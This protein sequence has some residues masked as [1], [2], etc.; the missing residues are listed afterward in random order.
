MSTKR[1]TKHYNG[2]LTGHCLYRVIP[3]PYFLTLQ[4]DGHGTISANALT[5]TPSAGY[6]FS[7]YESTGATIVGNDLTFGVED[8]TAKAATYT[9]T[10]QTDGHG[11]GYFSAT[12]YAP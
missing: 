2:H 9:L 6:A 5:A 10:L 11:T 7:N 4:T 8:C 12:G 1:L 3:D